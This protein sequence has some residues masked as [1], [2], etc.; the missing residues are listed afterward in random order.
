MNIISAKVT[1][2]VLSVGL[3]PFDVLLA[4]RIFM[5]LGTIG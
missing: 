5:K 1:L 3:L 4:E 2:F